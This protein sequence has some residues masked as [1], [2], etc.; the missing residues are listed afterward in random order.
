MLNIR[1]NAISVTFSGSL[2]VTADT[3]SYIDGLVQDCNISSAIA[4]EIIQCCTKPWTC[5]V[6]LETLPTI[7][8]KANTWMRHCY[9]HK[10]WIYFE[11]LHDISLLSFA[12]PLNIH[13]RLGPS[14]IARNTA[15]ARG[16]RAKQPEVGTDLPWRLAAHCWLHCVFGHSQQF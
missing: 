11:W 5:F 15:L 1:W 16:R 14:T 6:H 7:S 3:F 13:V 10:W 4:M 12:I 8:R 9:T 2:E